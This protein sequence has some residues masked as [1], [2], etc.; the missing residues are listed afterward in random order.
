VITSFTGSASSPIANIAPYAVEKTLFLDVV[1]ALTM[2]GGLDPTQIPAKLE[3]IT[4]G[5][6]LVSINPLTQQSTSR[7]TLFLANDNDFLG[8]LAPPVG[9]GDNQN[10]FFVFSF[11]DADLPGLVPQ[12]F[13]RDGDDHDH[14][15]RD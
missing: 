8:T 9:N 10:Q 13:H 3:G 2:Q 12:R 14:G 11:S 5:P 6:D 7:H 1:Q 15:D 4:F